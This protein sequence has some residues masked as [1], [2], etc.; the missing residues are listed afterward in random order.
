MKD[1]IKTIAFAILVFVCTV[2]MLSTT[3]LLVV[4]DTIPLYIVEDGKS[5]PIQ[6]YKKQVDKKLVVKDKVK[7]PPEFTTDQ[8]QQVEKVHKILK[9]DYGN[10]VFRHAEKASNKYGV[11][12]TLIMAVILTESGFDQYAKN[13]NSYGL[14][15]LS[16]N[17]GAS[18]ECDNLYSVKCNIHAST[19]HLAGLQAKYN[20]NDRLA[21][22]A[23]NAGGGLVDSSLKRRGDIPPCTRDYIYKVDKYKQVIKVVLY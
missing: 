15:Q 3:P 10:E 4:E 5:I 23:Y 8:K 11:D 18:K 16:D 17:T 22:A 9:S 6:E 2:Y 12:V 7:I 13:G 19:K 1:M 14:M 20:G 21:L